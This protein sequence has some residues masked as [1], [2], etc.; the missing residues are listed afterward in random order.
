MCH[1]YAPCGGEGERACC[2]AE[3]PLN[4]CD[5][6]LEEVPGCSGDCF[7]GAG[8]LNK[9][10]DGIEGTSI[11]TCVKFEDITEPSLNHTP[12]SP[13]TECSLRGYIDMHLHLF[14]DFAHGGALLAGRPF[15]DDLGGE[16]VND[17]LRPCYATQDIILD[18]DGDE[19]TLGNSSSS[20]GG[21][22]LFGTVFSGANCPNDIHPE[23]C[24]DDSFKFHGC[25]GVMDEAIG[26]FVG[27]G[28]GAAFS[29]GAPSFSDW[30]KWSSTTHQQAYY[31]WLE[32]AHRGGLRMVTMF[33]VTNGALCEGGIT[34]K[35]L[36]HAET[37][38]TDCEDSMAFIDLQ[39]EAAYDFENFIDRK[40]GGG[41]DTD[42]GWFRIVLTPLEARREIANGNM[43]VVL[44]IEMANLFNCRFIAPGTV[45]E[46]T[47]VNGIIADP[48]ACEAALTVDADSECDEAF[49]RSEVERY[50]NDFGVR[51]IFP[52]HNF[53]NAYGG[54]N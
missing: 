32:R 24:D 27:T 44:G 30:P 2:F 50:Y 5:G 47:P 4:P 17:A 43:A 28:D 29:L 9:V 22:V 45:S 49:V 31:R 23:S 12:P 51:H 54:A 40:V 16:D 39:L 53:D 25:H 13:S 33:A 48:A 35:F 18:S 3:R 6:G 37:E 14:A 38:L 10:N 21:C 19:Q 8:L 36:D 20:D 34:K 7:C 42:G 11:T 15:Y 52:I 26:S 41:V 46:C 1:R